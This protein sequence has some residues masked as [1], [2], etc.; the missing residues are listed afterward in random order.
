MNLNKILNILF[1]INIPCY[2]WDLYDYII[3]GDRSILIYISLICLTIFYMIDIPSRIVN[4]KKF[5]TIWYE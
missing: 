4:Y 5:K 3:I 1:V 2:I